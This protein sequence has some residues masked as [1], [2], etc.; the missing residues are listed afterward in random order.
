MIAA[1]SSAS[2]RVASGGARIASA[3]IHGPASVRPGRK[4]R[5]VVSGFRSHARVRVQF[6]VLPIQ[7]CCV[8]YVIPSIHRPGFLIP[9]DGRRTITVSMPGRWAQ[10]VA[11]S[12][13]SP[14]WHYFRRGQHIFVAVFTDT[15]ADYVQYFATVS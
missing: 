2:Q 8:S 11:S 14:D 1:P 10:C 12:C 7:N 9:Q 5:L 15:D 13:A 3:T 4:V 6:G